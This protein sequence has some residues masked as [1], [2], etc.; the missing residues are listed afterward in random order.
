MQKRELVGQPHPQCFFSEFPAESDWD[1]VIIGGGPNGLITGA[2]LA[3]AGLRIVVVERRYEIGGG[4][5]TE[6][7]LFPG[8]YSNIHAIY[9]LMVDFMPV[10]KDFQL[11][12]HGLVWIKPNLQTAMVFED[13][14]SVLLT[15]MLEDTA[16]SFHKYSGKDAVAF[17]KLMR[18]WRRIVKEIVAP[19]TYIPAMSPLDMSIAMQRTDIGREMLELVEQSPLDI[20]K[21]NFEDDRIRALLL[22]VSCMWGLDPRETGIGFFVPLLLDRGMNKSYLHGG[23]HKLAGALAREIIRAGGT[24]LESSDVTKIIMRNGSVS[25]VE[26]GEGRTLNSDVVISSLDPHT[27][28]LDLLSPEKVPADLKDSVQRWKY[29]KWSFNTVHIASE[30]APH[31][32]CG[33]PWVDESFMTIIGFESTDQLLAHWD[34]VVAGK[35]DDKALG[36]HATCESALDSHLVRKPGKHVSFFQ[37][38]APYDIEGGWDKRGPELQKAILA[39]WQKAAPNINTDNIIM[40]VQETPVDI[41]I[42]LPNMRRGSI[43]HGDYMPVQLGCFRPNQ[44]C[45]DHSTPIQGLYLCGASTYP[46]GLVL[47]G[48]GYLAANKVAED[49]GATKWWKP[50]PEM[51]K[52][53]KTYLD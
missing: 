1:A 45:S 20:I 19:A 16:D 53:T 12:R 30:E 28:F 3:R 14:G 27:T 22:Y 33:E 44:D 29:D 38:H 39:K 42:R 46:G 21:N 7:I 32:A 41:E 10:V 25:G 36:G 8:Y 24:I 50:T 5:A 17:G 26:L 49:L 13:G 23:S 31:Y 37:I 35:V 43:K 15:R 11:D 4:L 9:H 18:T 51:E 34:N 6:E 40:A 2:Y 47:G 48:P 52:F